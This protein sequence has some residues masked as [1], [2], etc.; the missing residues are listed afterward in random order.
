VLR[1]SHRI[2]RSRLLSLILGHKRISLLTHAFAC[3]VI[4]RGRIKIGVAEGYIGLPLFKQRL[5]VRNSSAI[6][7][8]PCHFGLTRRATGQ[9]AKRQDCGESQGLRRMMVPH[10][11]L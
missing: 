6:G 4:R 3:P 7:P 9:H 2:S 5:I 10:A 11:P 8:Y 1:R